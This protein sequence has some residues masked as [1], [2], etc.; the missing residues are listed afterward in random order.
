MNG[1]NWDDGDDGRAARGILLALALS[2][3]MISIVVLAVT[4]I[5]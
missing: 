4:Q 1:N 3:F 2:L 5:V